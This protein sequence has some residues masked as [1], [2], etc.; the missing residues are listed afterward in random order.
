MPPEIF[1]LD[2]FLEKKGNNKKILTTLDHILMNIKLTKVIS[3]P[4]TKDAS[5]FYH[6]ELQKY[7][8]KEYTNIKPE[9]RTVNPEL[10]GKYPAEFEKQKKEAKKY[11]ERLFTFEF[12][13]L[14]H[15][16]YKNYK[17]Q[18]DYLAIKKNIISA[19]NVLLENFLYILELIEKNEELKQIFLLTPWYYH[20]NKF[21][22]GFNICMHLFF[23]KE[24]EPVI[25]YYI[26]LLNE[27]DKCFLPTI[28][29]VN[30]EIKRKNLKK[31]SLKNKKK[32]QKQ[33]QLF[34]SNPNQRKNKQ[35]EKRRLFLSK[36]FP[37]QKLH[38]ATSNKS[39]IKYKR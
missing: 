3:D 25:K 26:N 12:N 37:M 31:Q 27:E 23:P 29:I 38:E 16:I 18:S 5:D 10:E 14:Q 2:S 20:K 24:L 36:K 13:Q 8:P 21:F 32:S 1:I 7:K 35:N 30:K 39:M 6:Q 11:K 34:Y 33:P 9:K 17:K 4:R 19:Y 15:I 28:E 22:P